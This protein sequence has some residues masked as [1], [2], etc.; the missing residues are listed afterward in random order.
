MKCTLHTV[1]A[2]AIGLVPSLVNA[3]PCGERA[4]MVTE[5]GKHRPWLRPLGSARTTILDEDANIRYLRILLRGVAGVDQ[6]WRLAIRDRVGRPLQSL[7][8][9][10][11]PSGSTF[12]TDRLPTNSVTLDIEQAST[13]ATVVETIE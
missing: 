11:L 3:E 5:F 7:S 2:F 4:S 1:M 8:H 6:P 9:G 12:W 13:E 10:D